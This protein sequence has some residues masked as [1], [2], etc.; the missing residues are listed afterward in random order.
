MADRTS[1]YPL[2]AFHF[3]VHFD[4]MDGNTADTMFHEV[5][6]LSSELIIEEVKEAGL[7]RHVHKLPLHAHNP[8]LVLRRGV[9][10]E[11]SPVIAWAKDAIHHFRF[12]PCDIH[13]MLLNENHEPVKTWFVAGAYPVK[14]EH[15]DLNSMKN[16]IL[17][18]T[19][20]LAYRFCELKS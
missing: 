5:T 10:P 16:E 1:Y 11:I 3:Q 14:L 12:K 8:N 7:N 2:P 9:F 15:G 13:I 6:G 20:T 17:V 18:E 4:G 19:L